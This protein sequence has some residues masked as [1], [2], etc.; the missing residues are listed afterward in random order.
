MARRA[1]IALV[2]VGCLAVASKDWWYHLAFPLVEPCDASGDCG[3]KPRQ[4]R[5][6]E[7]VAHKMT[8]A[9][10]AIAAKGPDTHFGPD[11]VGTDMWEETTWDDIISLASSTGYCETDSGGSC[12]LLGC[13]AT[14]GGTEC[15]SQKC[16]CAPGHCAFGGTCFPSDPTKCT[17]DTGG[18]CN[19]AF[20]AKSRGETECTG[21][22]CM[23]A[24]GHCASSGLCY[25]VTD[26]GG[27]CSMM[28]CAH[29]R[30]PTTCSGGRCL[31]KAG[32]VAVNGVCMPMSR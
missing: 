19:V 11:A 9:Q 18:T 14:R 31:C 28:S 2:V 25:A 17:Q 26:T 23:C 12:M 32:F 8:D 3:S 30:G 13:A 6:E 1:L 16:M 24:P 4:L 7:E 5:V 20:C 22:K 10:A 29:T 27:T 21:G 15:K